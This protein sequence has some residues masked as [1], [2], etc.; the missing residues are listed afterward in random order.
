MTTDLGGWV[1]MGS[2]VAAYGGV[3]PFAI[4]QTVTIAVGGHEPPWLERYADTLRSHGGTAG[5]LAEDLPDDVA[6]W[7]SSVRVADAY[8]LSLDNALTD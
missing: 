1:P 8:L 6:E 4:D 3:E 2:L 7:M 5:F